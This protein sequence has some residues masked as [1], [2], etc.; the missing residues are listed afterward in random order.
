MSLDNLKIG[1]RLAGAFGI[2]LFLLVSITGLGVY[3][4]N[5]LNQTAK[6]IIQNHAPRVMEANHMLDDI[7]LIAIAMRTSVIL[8]GQAQISEEIARIRAARVRIDEN[9][10]KLEKALSTPTARALFEAIL[11]GR[12]RY[13]GDQE[14]FLSLMAD[15]NTQEASTL[16]VRNIMESQTD[17]MDRVQQLTRFGNELI[18]S[19]G[20]QA[21][22]NYKTGVTIML[23]LALAAILL[24]SIFA[25]WV[26]R[27]ITRP[28][29]RAVAI[30]NSVASGDLGSRIDVQSRDETGQLMQALKNMNDSL[31]R[32]VNEVRHGAD[33][34][35]TASSQIASGNLDLSVRTEQQAEAITETAASMEQLTST[36]KQNSDN[37]SLANRLASSASQI[38]VKGGTA[39][40][41][42]V[43]TMEQINQSS[44]EI[45]D[46][47]AVIDSIA[48]QT[49]ILAL[50]AAVE[51]AR[52][53]QEGRGFAV[54]A[55]EVRS[56]AQR[57]AGAAQEIKALIDNSVSKVNEGSIQVVD[58]GKTMEEIVDSVKRV[59]D[60]MGEIAVA[61]QEQTVGIGQVNVAINQMD[62]T[63]QQNAAQVEEAATAAASLHDQTSA[64]SQLVG[65]FKL[66]AVSGVMH[67]VEAAVVVTPKLLT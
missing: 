61:S 1:Y 24:A 13:R 54:V 65:V 19:E 25:Y 42:L 7:N 40:M 66:G 12:A 17:Y 14:K 51:A 55:T 48:F 20:R 44:K 27:G 35:A 50:N 38:A 31:V 64:L 45:V 46:I 53:G 3:R 52:A 22:A 62:D 9:V 10:G 21:E 37:A 16:L 63:T 59:T 18:I 32:I 30:A 23:V 47:I 33:S 2:V 5:S 15:D 26:T 4:L 41:Q 43:D 39:V 57:S 67:R 6:L 34:I 56:L 28:L 49:N 58:A 60:I 11:E 8:G 36:V 29:R